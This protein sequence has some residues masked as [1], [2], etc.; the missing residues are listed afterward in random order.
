MAIA[1]DAATVLE[2]FVHDGNL[3]YLEKWSVTPANVA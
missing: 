3:E 1:E 2:Q